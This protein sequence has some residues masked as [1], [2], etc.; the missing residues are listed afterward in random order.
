MKPK[1]KYCQDDSARVK[2]LS[3]VA[4]A[5]FLFFVYLL[6]VIQSIILYSR[7]SEVGLNS[8]VL[9][10]HGICL[11]FVQGNYPISGLN[12]SKAC[13][14]FP[15]YLIYIPL[16]LILKEG[17]LSI[18]AFLCAFYVSLAGLYGLL[19][20]ILISR[21]I[22]SL[23]WGALSVNLLL[24]LQLFTT[25]QKYLWAWGMPGHHGGMVL[26]GLAITAFV[27]A[28]IRGGSWKSYR[29]PTTLLVF[30][31]TFSDLLI[32]VQFIIPLGVCLYLF[33]HKLTGGKMLYRDYN[34]TA[35]AGISIAIIANLLLQ[36]TQV[37]FFNYYIFKEVP[38]P[39]GILSQLE[40]LM[41][42]FWNHAWSQTGGFIILFAIAVLLAILLRSTQRTL[43]ECNR[44]LFQFYLTF[45]GL[46][47][48]FTL[49][50]PILTGSWTDWNNVRYY[51]NAF[52]LPSSVIFLHIGLLFKATNLSTSLK[53]MY[54]V[55]GTV[56]LLSITVY[57]GSKIDF[58]RLKFPY[59]DEIRELDVI[60][61]KRDLKWGL[62]EY[63][64][65]N[66]IRYFSRRD[67]KVNHIRNDRL[68]YFWLNNSF[69]FYKTTPQEGLEWPEYSFIV[70]DGLAP[71][72]LEN[73]FGSPQETIKTN[74]FTLFIYDKSGSKRIREILEPAVR[75]RL[76]GR[77]LKDLKV[78]E[79]FP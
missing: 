65:S 20:R 14:F 67:L 50:S 58:V 9:S 30:L 25:H 78:F 41:A 45:V 48:V 4:S 52:L 72:I 39:I 26:N 21:L 28:A 10:N 6:I 54:N 43:T 1:L 75:Q 64:N 68:P 73:R 33:R 76:K 17:G 12:L 3:I 59:P 56:A 35:F 63:W 49:P 2:Y 16:L 61:E 19:F 77:R 40:T 79:R 53:L 42:D 8:D 24:F 62:A 15:E 34:I 23:F 5:L 46:S 13:S 60:A 31:S 55:A 47:I 69:W 37:F 44:R 18:S 57:L 11:D 36:L 74:G 7:Y 71:V 51:I 22:S 32:I 70:A 66:R 27:L 29:K 38:N